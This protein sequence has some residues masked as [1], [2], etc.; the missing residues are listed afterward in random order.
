MK[1]YWY[2]REGDFLPE[3]IDVLCRSW[4]RSRRSI[5]KFLSANAN[6]FTSKEDAMQASRVVRAALNTS[7]P[8][9]LAK[10][11]NH[12]RQYCELQLLEKQITDALYVPQ[13]QETATHMD[14]RL[15]A[16]Q[17]I[18]SRKDYLTEFIAL[19]VVEQFRVSGMLSKYP[20]L[21]TSRSE[22]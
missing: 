6:I 7:V 15:A 16:E 1:N 17:E 5:V 11:E 22:T 18:H 4:K 3:E 8:E 12:V 13:S 9:W 21:H 10:L 14:I 2:L 19:A 20:E